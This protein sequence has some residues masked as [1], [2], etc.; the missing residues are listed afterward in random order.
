MDIERARKVL[1][2]TESAISSAIIGIEDEEIQTYFDE[3]LPSFTPYDWLLSPPLPLTP[4]LVALYGWRCDEDKVLE[5]KKCQSKLTL[6]YDA[7]GSREQRERQCVVFCRML[8]QAH[9]PECLWRSH[10]TDPCLILCPPSH[11]AVSAFH[12]R[13]ASFKHEKEV[14]I[15]P[16][17]PVDDLI[18][19]LSLLNSNK[20]KLVL[21][22]AGWQERDGRYYCSHCCRH[23]EMVPAF[24]VLTEHKPYCFFLQS[25]S[26]MYSLSRHLIP[27]GMPPMMFK[28]TER[29]PFWKW[30]SSLLMG[31][32]DTD[33][34]V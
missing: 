7:Q 17:L 29:P 30:L 27:D 32:K 3:F 31:Q 18:E 8:Q 13:L 16:D 5:C 24:D 9:Q 19:G 2:S 22:V 10:R 23:C 26:Q 12:S 21:A 25:R 15:P 4:M 34:I 20:D 33:P 14:T 6:K 28:K 1:K 11:T